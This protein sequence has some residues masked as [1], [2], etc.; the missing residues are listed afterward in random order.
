MFGWFVRYGRLGWF[1]RFEWFGM[2]GGLFEMFFEMC[3]RLGMFE[4][5][6]GV[7]DVCKVW[8]V[9]RFFSKGSVGLECLE[10]LDG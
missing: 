5:R 4:R 9:C 7:W 1:G 6:V 3:D 10:G 2:F 8:K